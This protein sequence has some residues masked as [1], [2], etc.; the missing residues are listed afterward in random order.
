MVDSKF[1]PKLPPL[2]MDKF[3]NFSS[4]TNWGVSDPVRFKVLMDEVKTLVSPPYYFGDNF[5]TWLRNNSAMEDVVFRN[6]W[7][8]N[9]ANSSDQA[10]A[11]RRYI[12]AC[13][14]YHCLNLPGDFAEFGVYRGTGVKTVIDYLGGTGFP[15]TFWA[16]D[17]F[18]YNPV[19]GHE[20]EGQEPG[21]FDKV[22]DRFK[23]YP[24]V[25][26]IKGLLPDSFSQGMPES[27]S[28]MH[29]DLN[30]H[31]G[32]IAVLDA[33]FDR[34]IPGGILILDDYEWAGAYRVQKKEEDQWFEKR[35]YR[36]FPI[37][38]GQGLI[39]KR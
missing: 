9:I 13:A 6:A 14:A 30:N 15:K 11:W 21:F 27:L 28:Y 20:F 25:K 1:F 37:P 36:V 39:I 38:T 19:Q 18:D 33:L 10:L 5:F 31:A 16:Y 26:L 29:I 23:D 17:T 32:E 34:L 8:S 4:E 7:Q 12:L 22:K 2:P 3:I 24:Q 35:Q